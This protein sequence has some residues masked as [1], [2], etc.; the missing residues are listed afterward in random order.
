MKKSVRF[1]ALLLALVLAFP[2]SAA[3]EHAVPSVSASAAVL[4]EAESGRI[5]YGKN[6]NL[7]RG[8]ASTTKIMTAIVAIE[9]AT[10]QKRVTVAPAAVGVEG[11]SVYLSAGEETTI[12]TLLYALMLQSANDAAAAL[13]YEI[14]GGIEGFA[15]MMN[16]KAKALG[17]SDTHFMNPHGLDDDNHYTTAYEL[18]KIAA[19]A[20]Q[21]ESFAEIV[22]TKKKTIPLHDG[23]A[24]RLLVNHNR[25]LREYEDIIG[26]KTGFT[27][28]CGRTLVS[29]AE[30]DGVRLICVT[31][32]DGDDWRDHRALLDFGFSLYERVELAKAGELA[33]NVHV[34]GGDR[35]SVTVMN[36]EPCFAVLPKSHGKLTVVTELPRFLYGG[37]KKGAPIGTARY[38]MN[39]AEIA[40][41]VLYAASDA[42]VKPKEKSI[43]QRLLAFWK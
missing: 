20:L 1:A 32:N 34:C 27:K 19:Y 42:S 26:V 40:S 23:S 14:A 18:A 33:Y 10:L 24:T 17:L 15:D 16:A 3:A 22:S 13:A 29:A 41:V 6:E 43:L 9:H 31:L 25:L 28:K 39:G 35:A 12:E 5:L 30:R 21:N 36:T 11:S 4:I 2:I 8:M 38:Y 7:R 37:V